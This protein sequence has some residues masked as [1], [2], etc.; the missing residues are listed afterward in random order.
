L[1]NVGDVRTLVIEGHQEAIR[2]MQMVIAP[3]A[4]RTMQTIRTGGKSRLLAGLHEATQGFLP[5]I[6][7]VTDHFR[8]AGLSKQQSETLAHAL[9]SG[10]MR[11]YFRAGR[12]VL[13]EKEQE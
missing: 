11:S 13:S 7:S 8:A 12:R 10:S 3:A 4:R 2:R 1:V 5:V 9:V 6:V